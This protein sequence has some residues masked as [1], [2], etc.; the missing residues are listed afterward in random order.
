MTRDNANR[1]YGVQLSVLNAYTEVS[2]SVTLK[3]K[4][5]A[6][7]VYNIPFANLTNFHF[8]DTFQMYQSLSLICLQKNLKITHTD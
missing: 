2:I 4:I 6:E 1:Q 8:A 7:L 3:F 5:T